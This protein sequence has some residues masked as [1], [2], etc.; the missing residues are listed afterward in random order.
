MKTKYKSF[1]LSA[2]LYKR[3][4]GKPLSDFNP[5]GHNDYNR[6]LVLSTTAIG[7]TLFSTPA[8]KALREAYPSAMI[9]LMVRD[10]LCA[11]F[12]SNPH[13]N[14]IIPFRKG[15]IGLYRMLKEIEPENFDMA[16][17]LHTSDPLPV[18]ASVLSGIPYVV[19]KCLQREFDFLYSKK[20]VPNPKDH[21]I[22]RR[23]T[24]VREI[25]PYSEK[26]SCRMIL[27]IDSNKTEDIWKNVSLKTGIPI[28]KNVNIRLIG[29]QPGANERF[30]M[31]PAENFISLGKRILERDSNSV[32]LIF[33]SPKERSLGKAIKRGINN[34]ERVYSLCGKTSITEFPHIL[35]KLDF[36]VTNDTGTLHIAIA[37]ETP[38]VSLFVG[39]HS[40][41]NGPYQDRDIHIVIEKE[42]PCKEDICSK[43]NRP[44]KLAC[45]ALITVDEV[46]GKIQN[47]YETLGW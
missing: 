46:A 37:L 32:I 17:V 43:K 9:K 36:L 47:I 22:E 8:I 3:K 23:L 16:V 14:G 28:E 18:V 25:I 24:V 15:W 41:R 45:M 27:P 6:I 20:V 1:F 34:K 30:R 5:S 40:D 12:K 31:W 42:R 35:K 13:I 39:S 7:D 2:K 26:F 33:G 11:L 21:T 29:F 4:T 19:G 38:T 44:C 10:R